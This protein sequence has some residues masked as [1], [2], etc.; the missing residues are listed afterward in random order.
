MLEVG[1]G[2]PYVIIESP[3]TLSGGQVSSIDRGHM[4]DKS[5]FYSDVG[6]QK[7]A[8]TQDVIDKSTMFS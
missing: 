1:C 3:G 2:W 5:A 4:L 6:C 8:E 7:F